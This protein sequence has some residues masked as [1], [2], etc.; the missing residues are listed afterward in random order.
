MN[1][2]R[3]RDGDDEAGVDLE[4]DSFITDSSN[5]NNNNN[6]NNNNDLKTTN[7]KSTDALK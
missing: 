3:V 6:N 7:G 2:R 4:N 1:D 5:D